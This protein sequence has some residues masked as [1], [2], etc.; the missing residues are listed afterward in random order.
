MPG[1]KDKGAISDRED[2][3]RQAME[4]GPQQMQ[5]NA[6]NPMPTTSQAEIF[7]MNPGMQ[8][9]MEN[10]FKMS[11]ARKRADLAFLGIDD[12]MMSDTEVNN[13]IIPPELQ[14][15]LNQQ[16]PPP[17]MRE[18]SFKTDRL[19]TEGLDEMTPGMTDTLDQNMMGALRTFEAGK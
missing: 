8:E 18:E 6:F 19:L 4:M 13:Y 12:S 9:E 15:L 14:E 3:L 17:E 10:F 11:V 7:R 2:T 1:H 16:P 5:E